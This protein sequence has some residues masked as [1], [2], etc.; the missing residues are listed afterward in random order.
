MAVLYQMPLKSGANGG[1]E[2][3]SG[4]AAAPNAQHTRVNIS[5]TTYESYSEYTPE[6]LEW[7]IKIQT[8]SPGQED[9]VRCSGSE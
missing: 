9:R 4:R 5:P 3:S 2:G 7:K 1:G 6:F 8:Q